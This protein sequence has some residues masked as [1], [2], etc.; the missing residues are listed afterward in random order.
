V[1]SKEAAPRLRVASRCWRQT[2]LDEDVADGGRRDTNTELA[3]FADDAQV[4]PTR[5]LAGEPQDQLAHLTADRRPTR[6]AMRIGPAPSDQPAM[7]GQERLRLHEEGVPG[8]ARQNTAARRQEQAVVR[9]QPRPRD[10]TAK[11][12]Q[13]MAE[14]ENLELLGSVSAADEHDQLEQPADND[15]EG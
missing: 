9:P 4:A 5:I 13:L 12:R 2:G 10:L 14:H 8:A 3:Q 11:D 7:P 1:R 15:V 6:G